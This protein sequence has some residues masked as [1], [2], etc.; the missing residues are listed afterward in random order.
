MHL[1]YEFR[2]DDIKLSEVY[3]EYQEAS[4]SSN[5]A[6]ECSIP[7][8]SYTMNEIARLDPISV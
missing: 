6:I 1:L 3:K 4:A 7:S 8:R 5:Y 2:N